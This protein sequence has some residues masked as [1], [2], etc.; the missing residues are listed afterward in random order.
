MAN[1]PGVAVVTLHLANL[2]TLV[3]VRAG[4]CG[5]DADR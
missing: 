2:M 5:R 3:V 4:K 1:A